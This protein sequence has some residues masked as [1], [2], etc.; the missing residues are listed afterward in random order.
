MSSDTQTLLDGPVQQLL[1]RAEITDRVAD[2]AIGLDLLDR[3]RYR[4]CFADLVEI[5]NPHFAGTP[6][7]RQVP[8]DEWVESV[9]SRQARFDVR[10]HVL[11]NS[12]IA[13]AGDEADVVLTQQATFGVD[14]TWYRVAG[15]LRLH[16][17]RAP[18]WCITGLEYEVRT[19]EGDRALY[20]LGWGRDR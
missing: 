1:D 11:S 9:L 8:G 15:P 20:E 2:L 17:H 4:R 12:A 5:R 18:H 3:D 7:V 16:M 13:I 14:A 10:V 19:I 6:S